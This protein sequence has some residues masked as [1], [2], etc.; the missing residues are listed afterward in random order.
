MDAGSLCCKDAGGPR[1]YEARRART[2]RG[3]RRLRASAAPLLRALGLFVLFLWNTSLCS[4]QSPRR[5]VSL[6]PSVTEILFD[7]GAGPEVVGV[8]APADAPP[9]AEGLTV[10]ASHERVDLERIVALQPGACF[11]VE[12]MQSPEALLSLRR[13][14]VTVH[15]YPMRSLDDLWAC[16]GDVGAKVGRARD[17]SRRAGELRAR[18]E[19]VRAQAQKP[20]VPAAV[21]VGLEPLVAVGGG[22]FLDGV[23]SACGLSNVLSGRGEP[24]PQVSLE[25]LAAAGPQVLLFPEGE[26]P[27]RV[28]EETASAL[29][30]LR[31]ARVLLIGVPAD[32]LVRPG[33]RTP[34]AVERIARKLREGPPP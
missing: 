14:G 5:W 26:V 18:I 9:G 24:Y 30:K 34:D 28:M 22:S 33:P 19:R 1:R 32:L 21:V 3:V 10:V 4:Q 11:T 25:T 2:C 12:G 31:G 13:L 6:A 20:P 16:Y 17:A 8:C 7:I 23:L 15:A 27:G 29:E